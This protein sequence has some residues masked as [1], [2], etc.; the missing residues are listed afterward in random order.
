MSKLILEKG[1]RNLTIPNIAKQIR[2]VY[3]VSSNYTIIKYRNIFKDAFVKRVI[4]FQT[5]VGYFVLKVL[6]KL[7][8]F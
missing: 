1:D 8:I 3:Q 5:T 6:N 2:V 7:K 4:K